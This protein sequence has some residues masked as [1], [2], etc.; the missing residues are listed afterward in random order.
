[1]KQIDFFSLV[2]FLGGF[3]G[4]HNLAFGELSWSFPRRTLIVY[5]RGG[6]TF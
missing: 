4:A 1:M 5:A 2:S 6:Q 3:S